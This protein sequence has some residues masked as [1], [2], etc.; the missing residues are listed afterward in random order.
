MHSLVVKGTLKQE[1]IT[2][3]KREGPT[4]DNPLATNEVKKEVIF[5]LQNLYS[6]TV[7]YH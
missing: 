5:I 4:K 7:F 6:G 2:K 1:N 3:K